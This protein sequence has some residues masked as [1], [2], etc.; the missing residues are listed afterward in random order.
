[1]YFRRHKAHKLGQ[2]QPTKLG[3]GTEALCACGARF[4]SRD[5]TDIRKMHRD[6]VKAAR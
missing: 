6:H 3:G 1:M 4:H 2:Y 5:H